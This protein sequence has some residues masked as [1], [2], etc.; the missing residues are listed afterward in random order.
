M[1][2]ESNSSPTVEPAKIIAQLS[3][4]GQPYG[5]AVDPRTGYLYVSGDASDNVT[6][7]NGTHAIANLPAGSSPQAAM[8]DPDDGYVYVANRNS[9]DVTVIQ[10][11]TVVATIS[12]DLDGPYNM[13]FDPENDYVYVTD[14]N[15][16]PGFV[17]VLQGTTVIGEVTTGTFPAGAAY[18]PANGY[19]YVANAAAAENGGASVTVIDATTTIATISGNMST[20]IGVVYDPQDGDIY[21]ADQNFYQPTLG[22]VTVINGLHEVG[23][24]G[25]GGSAWNAAYDPATGNVYVTDHDSDNVTVVRGL[26]GVGSI[27]VGLE[28]Y[29][30]LY[31]PSTG[32]LYVSASESNIVD[33]ISTFL[34]IGPIRNVGAGAAEVGGNVLLRASVAVGAG[35]DVVTSSVEP[36]DVL[37]CADSANLSSTG[38]SAVVTLRCTPTAVGTGTVWFNVTD[39]LENTVWSRASIQVFGP[40]GPPPLAATA[41][42]AS[43]GARASI[44]SADVGQ[45]VQFTELP[46]GGSGTYASF[47]WFVL[48]FGSCNATTGPVLGCLFASP[49]T[50]SVRVN[51]T[52]QDGS[53]AGP[54][55]PATVTIDPD[56]VVAT[57]VVTPVSLPEGNPVTMTVAVTGGSG[58]GNA[59]WIGVPAGCGGSTVV[60]HCTPGELG[61]FAISVTYTDTNDYTATSHSTTLTVVANATTPVGRT[62]NN[63]NATWVTPGLF[64]EVL[65]IALVA[66]LIAVVALAVAL[67]APRWPPPP[68]PPGRYG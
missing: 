60:V 38:L 33:A 64:Y 22:W 41:P 48:P 44:S 20:P 18:D 12:Q 32:L 15:S 28:P 43:S 5:L 17:T 31:D 67:S 29:G 68:M 37:G 10:G 9:N 7:F 50:V 47:E 53:T 24:V 27:T 66:I 58:S 19:I 6:V 56:P 51:V 55:P 61:E 30:V 39:S 36:A 42:S 21:V 25:A 54:S 13:A 45:L 11:T 2:T 46:T 3:V 63:G 26:T 65:A 40:G 1:A 14:V 8:Y 35:G 16:E 49:A 52:D 62:G 57:P 23:E 59:S 34:G 4:P